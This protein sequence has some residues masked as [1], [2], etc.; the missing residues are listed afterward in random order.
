MHSQALHMEEPGN[1]DADQRSYQDQRPQRWRQFGI[2]AI[3]SNASRPLQSVEFPRNVCHQN[4]LFFGHGLKRLK[5][6]LEFIQ[7]RAVFSWED[8]APLLRPTYVDNLAGVI[9]EVI[10]QQTT[11]WLRK[12]ADASIEA[13]QIRR[14]LRHFALRF[15]IGCPCTDGEQTQRD[16]VE[17]CDSS[18]VKADN[19]IMRALDVHTANPRP[20]RKDPCQAEANKKAYSKQFKKPVR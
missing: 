20:G 3:Q 19:I 5:I 15:G 18:Q 9:A 2:H 11:R 12:T 10:L 17:Y 16:P 6:R 7:R 1:H 4:F 14:L 13:G 8:A